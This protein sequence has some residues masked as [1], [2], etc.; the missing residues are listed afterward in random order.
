MI[1]NNND[2]TCWVVK[3]KKGIFYFR[4]LTIFN[5]GLSSGNGMDLLVGFGGCMAVK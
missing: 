5:A 1:L 4:Y 2:H 3:K